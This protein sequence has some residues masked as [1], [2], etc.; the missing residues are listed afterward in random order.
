MSDKETMPEGAAASTVIDAVGGLG[1]E[2]VESAGRSRKFSFSGIAG[3]LI[4]AARD[5]LTLDYYGRKLGERGLRDRST[6]I[7]EFGLDNKYW[8]NVRGL[9]EWLFYKYFRAAL[10]G[11]N[12]VPM[13]GRAI[14]VPNHAG[15]MPLDGIM[16]K[17]AMQCEHASHRD[18]R[19]LV[20]DFVYHLPFAG[21]FF[22]RIGGVRACQEN[23][24]RLLRRGELIATFPDG[25]QG[26]G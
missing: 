21:A 17:V 9:Y 2:L 20:E 24:E 8:E 10:K 11:I 25:I 15:S 3:D 22:N 26:V 1:D 18:V 16:L 23:A 7:D 14:L 6:E 19:F 4:V 5:L 12:N 13:K